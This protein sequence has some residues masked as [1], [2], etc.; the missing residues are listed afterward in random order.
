ML[1]GPFLMF[2]PLEGTEI[3]CSTFSQKLKVY[4]DLR[5][6]CCKSGV[7]DTVKMN[8][9]DP[10]RKNTLCV[11]ISPASNKVNAHSRHASMLV[12]D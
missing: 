6:G 7:T 3:L 4:I 1:F 10:V 12:M 11:E 2:S 8:L 9:G 5:L